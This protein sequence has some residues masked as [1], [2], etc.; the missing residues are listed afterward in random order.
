MSRKRRQIELDYTF[1]GG[2]PPV[3]GSVIPPG[4]SGPLPPFV[5]GHQED[6]F[7]GLDVRS[8]DGRQKIEFYHKAPYAMKGADGDARNEYLVNLSVAAQHIDSDA[9]TI[10]QTLGGHPSSPID[11]LRGDIA[12]RHVLIERKVNDLN[13]QR[14]AANSYFG[15]SPFGKSPV[16]YAMATHR[17]IQQSRLGPPALKQ[18]LK[19]AY[20]AAYTVQ[21][22]EAEIQILHAQIATLEQAVANAEVQA[23]AQR[24]AHTE[25]MAR[26]HEEALKRDHE[27]ALARVRAIAEAQARAREVAAKAAVER[28]LAEKAIREANTYEVLLT[29]LAVNPAVVMARGAAPVLDAGL[30]LGTAIRAAVASLGAASIEAVVGPFLVGTFALL[31]SPKL[32]NGELQHNYVL[33]AP[34]TDL[35]VEL[36]AA[37][38]AAAI[39]R[40]AVDLPIRMGDKREQIGPTELFAA[41]TDGAVISCAVPVLAAQ[42]DAQNGQYIVTTDDVPPRTL[43]WTPAVEPTDSS[44]ALPAL[45]P[46]ITA[47]VGPMLEPLE[48]RLDIYP[49]LPDI[50]FDDY[51]IIFPADSGLPPLYVMFKSP[52]NMPGV[53][54]GKG[55]LIQGQFL[56][57][58]NREGAPIPAQIAS[59]L[60]G[61][62]FSSFGA[63]RRRLWQLIGRSPL[64]EGQFDLGELLIMRRGLAPPVRKNERVGQ[65]WK[66]EIHHIKRIVDGGAVYDVENMTILSPKFHIEAHVEKKEL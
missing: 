7:R 24:Q 29:G 22:R 36:D 14:V 47:L 5:K 59:K 62:K 65:R 33:S 19:N 57:E 38:Q 60:R 16:D 46:P 49:D 48:G 10:R 27:E 66:F 58:G 31:Y 53:V 13:A 8:K 21:L 20:K 34:L 15:S 12:A 6:W 18:A 43:V 56:Y 26:A 11:A 2:K 52:R 39:E 23:E 61:K 64:F 35:T 9:R 45:P 63:F 51:V 54:T 50:G 28:T 32:G 40:G 42:Y 3:G 17:L 1:I 25:A 44:T 41:R 4:H 55:R 37:A 30:T